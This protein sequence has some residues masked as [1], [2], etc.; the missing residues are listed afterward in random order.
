MSFAQFLTL[1]VAACLV[2]L[3][4]LASL[5][6]LA[7]AVDEITR[8]S[9]TLLAIAVVVRRRGAAQWLPVA[10][11]LAL[12]AVLANLVLP[13]LGAN[14]AFEVEAP[15]LGWVEIGWRLV[16]LLLLLRGQ[17]GWGDGA[18]LAMCVATS[19]AGSLALILSMPFQAEVTGGDATVLP[20][21]ALAAVAA[22]LTGLVTLLLAGLA[23]GKASTWG[24]LQRRPVLAWLGVLACVVQGAG[25]LRP[26]FAGP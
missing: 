21:E 24:A 11:W 7:F 3:T 9:A 17:G 14:P 6:G 5:I 25:L 8:L 12:G 13:T 15:G 2:L 20:S 4:P 26:W 1:L 23:L 18:L 10:G 16:F 19:H 22:V